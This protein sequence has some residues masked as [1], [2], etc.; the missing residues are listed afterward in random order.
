MN[1]K[2]ISKVFFLSH[3]KVTEI[4]FALTYVFN[5]KIT[6][7]TT[8]TRVVKRKQNQKK[9]TN[10]SKRNQNHYIAIYYCLYQQQ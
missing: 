8:I 5:L 10:T 1:K 6:L 2:E 7:F 4:C 3:R 9:S